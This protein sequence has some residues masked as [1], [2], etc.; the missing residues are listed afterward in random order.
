VQSVAR[1]ML[2]AIRQDLL[3]AFIRELSVNIVLDQVIQKAMAPVLAQVER[4]AMIEGSVGGPGG[5]RFVLAILDA[6]KSSGDS[7]A[8]NGGPQ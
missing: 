3:Q 2:H 6:E 5:A 1:Q 8:A 7:G 4:E